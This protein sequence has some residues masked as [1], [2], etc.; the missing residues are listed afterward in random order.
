MIIEIKS[1]KYIQTPF[2]FF[3]V[4]LDFTS[5]FLINYPEYPPKV[6][7]TVTS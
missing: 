4:P 1:Y 2:K 6:F 3:N 7:L 5:V